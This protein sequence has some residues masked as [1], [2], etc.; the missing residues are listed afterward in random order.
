MFFILLILK[1]FFINLTKHILFVFRTK[2]VFQNS[3]P[4][5]NFIFFENTKTYFLKTIF[6]NSF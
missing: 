5:H 1:N 3:V 6:Q 4:K 2:T